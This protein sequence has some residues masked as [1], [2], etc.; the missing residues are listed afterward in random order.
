[1]SIQRHLDA[2]P[3][4]HAVGAMVCALLGVGGASACTSTE[5]S[6]ECF[7]QADCACGLA[8]RNG[9]CEPSDD[10][11]R[12]CADTSSGDA[13]DTQGEGGVCARLLHDQRVVVERHF[14]VA[15]PET[16]WVKLIGTSIGI[17][18]A[19]LRF[20][21]LRVE[22]GAGELLRADDFTSTSG[23]HIASGGIGSAAIE[24][25]F[26]SITADWGTFILEGQG[27][28]TAAGLSVA[29]TVD[30]GETTN[31]AGI[32]FATAPEDSSSGE[33]NWA[34]AVFDMGRYD[35]AQGEPHAHFRLLS[36]DVEPVALDAPLPVG[37]H[38]FEATLRSGP[39]E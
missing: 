14:A 4:R 11:A 15:A 31:S 21:W 10:P 7:A 25:G 18:D 23:W 16:L 30:W 17:Q 24:G 28:G 35:V 36:E 33:E 8:C 19:D 3:S 2:P 20:S 39:C 9:R 13:A 37:I 12:A 34:Y 32:M 27:F 6:A 29:V 22:D 1:M 5:S 26:A 38:A